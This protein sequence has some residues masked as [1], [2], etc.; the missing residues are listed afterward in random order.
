MG[1]LINDKFINDAG[2]QQTTCQ[3]VPRFREHVVDLEIGEFL[4]YRVEI[5]ICVPFRHHI[6][7]RTGL[8]ECRTI[9][10]VN[11]EDRGVSGQCEHACRQRHPQAVVQN[12]AKRL[13]A[14]TDEAFLPYRQRRIVGK[15]GTDTRQDCPR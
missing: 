9:A 12:D 6:D 14:L 4:Q 3:R 15:H 13:H 1:R 2:C 11:A 7:G 5:R 10:I 8:F